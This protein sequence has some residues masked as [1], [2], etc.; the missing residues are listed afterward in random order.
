MPAKMTIGRRMKLLR[1][2]LDLS[3]RKFGTLIGKTAETVAAYESDRSSPRADDLAKL[4]ELGINAAPYVLGTNA[5]MFEEP[6]DEVLRR[7]SKVLGQDG[8]TG[9]RPS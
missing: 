2:A 8:A 7:V 1:L 9:H 6:F 5:E 4:H 3:Q